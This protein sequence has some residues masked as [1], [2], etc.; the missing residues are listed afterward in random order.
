MSTTIERPRTNLGVS[1]GLLVLEI[2]ADLTRR[3][4]LIGAGLIVLAHACGNDGKTGDEAAVLSGAL[5]WSTVLSLPF[6]PDGLVP[7]L[8]AAVD[9]GPDTEATSA[10]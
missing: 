6:A 7:V 10:S 3:E 1:P 2:E 9:G 8:A 5:T 4:F